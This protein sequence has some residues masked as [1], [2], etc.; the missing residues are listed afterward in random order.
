MKRCCCLSLCA[1]IV[2]CSSTVTVNLNSASERTFSLPHSLCHSL[3]GPLIS[4]HS[5][6]EAQSSMRRRT[7]NN[8][9]N[10]NQPEPNQSCTWPALCASTSLSTVAARSSCSCSHC[11]PLKWTICCSIKGAQFGEQFEGSQQ[12]QHQHHH[13]L[14]TAT[15]V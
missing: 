14:T 12:E 4:L 6:N 10:N 13:T 3:C 7:T 15:L 11:F 8:S 2:C 5:S 9:N 1:F